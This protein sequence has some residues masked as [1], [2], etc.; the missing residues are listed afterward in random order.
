MSNARSLRARLIG[1]AAAVLIATVPLAGRAA[2]PF[3]INAILPM[4]GL[5]SFLGKEEAAALSV[6]EDVVNKGGGIGGR[7]IKFTVVDDQSSPQLGVQLLNGVMAKKPAVILG[8]SLVAICSAMLPLVKDGPT[9]YCFSPGVHPPEGSYAFSSSI[10]TTDLLAASAVYFHDRG[11]RKIAIITSTDASGQDAERGIDAAFNAQSGIQIIDREHFNITDVSVAAQM[12][13]IKSSGA[14]ALIAWSSGTPIATILRGLADAGIDMPVE[15]TN[16]NLTYA[17]MKAYAQFMPKEL[18]FTAPPAIAPDQLP[19][20]AV[21]RAV[22]AYINAFKPSGTRPDIGQALAWDPTMLVL[23]AYKKLGFNAT[24]EQIKDFIDGQ[25]NW[26]GINGVYD[27]HA[28]PQRGVGV[29]SVLMVRW[30]PAKDT[31][32]GVSKLGG[33]PL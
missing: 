17:Q 19:S 26:V 4:T 1:F 6:I 15:T 18:Y 16:A 23:D 33:K 22:T 7:P 13:H 20:G 27:F 32:V 21:K 24:A 8:S 28:V 11:W 30:D 29:G 14:Q 25:R 3:E 5:A 31:W 10:S 2:D 12:A 9:Q